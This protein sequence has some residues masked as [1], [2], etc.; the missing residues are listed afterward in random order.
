MFAGV[1]NNRNQ[2][3]NGVRSIWHN[4]PAGFTCLFLTNAVFFIV[5]F[6]V[7]LFNYLPNF[8]YYTINNVQLWRLFTS[9]LFVGTG[10]NGI[11]SIFITYY[12]LYTILVPIVSTR[13]YSN[14]SCLQLTSSVKFSFKLSF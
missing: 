13:L 5:G 6:I 2:D 12:M 8:I 9:F 14:A 4:F 3:D 11:I 10:I 7:P 1:D